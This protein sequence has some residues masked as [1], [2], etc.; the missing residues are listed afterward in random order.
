[1]LFIDL[2]YFEYFS[3]VTVP[4]NCNYCAFMSLKRALAI[5]KM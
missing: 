4:L 2:N 5:K 1:M 3:Q